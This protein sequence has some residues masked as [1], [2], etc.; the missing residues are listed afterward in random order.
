MTPP[1]AGSLICERSSLCEVLLVSTD[2]VSRAH[3]MRRNPLLLGGR[4][5]CGRGADPRKHEYPA[6]PSSEISL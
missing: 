4:R 6:S 2:T 5:S 3:L 1:F